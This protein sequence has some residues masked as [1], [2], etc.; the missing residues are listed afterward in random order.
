[1]KKE[2]DVKTKRVA[3][4]KS[5]TPVDVKTKRIAKR[6]NGKYIHPHD[7]LTALRTKMRQVNLRE[8]GLIR[9]MADFLR[10]VLPDY[11]AEHEPQNAV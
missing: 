6:R 7:K 2:S 1:M 10:K 9:R 4:R 11:T 3:K 5:G 8:E